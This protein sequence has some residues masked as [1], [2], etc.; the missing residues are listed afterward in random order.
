M[1]LDKLQDERIDCLSILTKLKVETFLDI[2]HNAYE[3]RGGIKGQR[4]PLKTKTALTIRKRLVSD[5]SDGA[6]IPPIVI[7]IHSPDSTTQELFQQAEDTDSLLAIIRDLPGESISIIDG[8]QRTTAFLEASEEHPEIVGRDQRVEFWITDNLGSLIYRMLVLN[9]GQVPWEVARQLETVYSQ[10][11]KQIRTALS[12]DIEVFLRDDERRRSD[13]GQYQASVL[14]RL[15]LAF[16]SRKM[17]FDL[18]DKVAEDFAR[19]DTVEASSHTEFLDHFIETIRLLSLLDK[20]F[21]RGAKGFAGKDVRVPDGK[22][23][24]QTFPALVGFVVSIAITIYDQPGF[25][26]EWGDVSRKL[27][28]I[29]AAIEGLV[30]R[31]ERLTDQEVEQFLALDI[32][33]E[34]LAIRTGQVGR[35]ERDIFFK[36][37]N[38]LASNADRLKD[39]QPCWVA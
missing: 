37:F 6:V 1:P 7:G 3:E 31:L 13:A 14:I 8:M 21:S 36:A 12:D 23:L 33:N 9:T 25:E 22:V 38:S 34:R 27:G 32:L 2:V 28:D 20:Q 17:E 39:M 15:F 11:I 26:V 29:T 35:F 19:I 5:L 30:A 24:F 10:L 4:S 18:K 16:A